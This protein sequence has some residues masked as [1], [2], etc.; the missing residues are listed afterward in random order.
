MLNRIMKDESGVLTFE[1][2]LLITLLVIGIVG[3]VA[4]IRDALIIETA[5]TAGA[6]MALDNSYVIADPLE[7][8]LKETSVIVSVTD[9]ISGDAEGSKFT[10]VAGTTTVQTDTVG[11]NGE[12]AENEKV[13]Q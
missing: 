1:W 12:A 6:I 4:I 2:I 10:D 7:V 8:V 9:R 5:E 13:G 3:G 11:L